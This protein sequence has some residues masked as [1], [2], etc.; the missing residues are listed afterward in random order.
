[1]L[2]LPGCLRTRRKKFRTKQVN[3]SFG[4]DLAPFGGWS[5]ARKGS[6]M[7]PSSMKVRPI[8]EVKNPMTTHKPSLKVIAAK[9]L[10]A[11]ESARRPEKSF[12]SARA[13]CRIGDHIG[14]SRQDLRSRFLALRL[15]PLQFPSFWPMP[16]QPDPGHDAAYG[17]T[18]Q[19]H[20]SALAQLGHAGKCAT[21]AGHSAA[22]RRGDRN[23]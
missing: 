7:K 5:Q 22:N 13:L 4:A 23:P 2:T 8:L 19:A 1:M 17:P 15:A 3:Y 10:Q 12:G 11:G 18:Q 21:D 16:I 14:H 9:D 20:S 6:S